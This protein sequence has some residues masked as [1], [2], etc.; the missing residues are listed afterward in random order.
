MKLEFPRQIFQ[1]HSSAKIPYEYVQWDSSSTRMD[2]QTC[3]HDEA[4]SHFGHS[5]NAPTTSAFC[6]ACLC[7]LWINGNYGSIQHELNG[8]YNQDW[9]CLLRGT[10]WTCINVVQIELSCKSYT[11][12]PRKQ[13]AASVTY[14]QSPSAHSDFRGINLRKSTH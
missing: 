7:V 11:V 3:T 9:G 2:R 8:F 14:R 1:K 4:N 5:A 13:D 10:N 6:W 12:L